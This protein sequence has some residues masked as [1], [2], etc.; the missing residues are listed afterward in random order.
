MDGPGSNDLAFAA[1][2]PVKTGADA[3]MLQEFLGASFVC[4]FV[5]REREDHISFLFNDCFRTSSHSRAFCA[6]EAES[7]QSFRPDVFF[8]KALTETYPLALMAFSSE[9]AFSRRGSGGIK[10]MKNKALFLKK[11]NR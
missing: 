1:W 3:C 10:S 7:R 9:A 8:E 4:T 5:D 2:G 6:C 11:T